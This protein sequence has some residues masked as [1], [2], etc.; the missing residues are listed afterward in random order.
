MKNRLLPLLLVT[1]AIPL[2]IFRAEIPTEEF[3]VRWFS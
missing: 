3:V 2:Q 1:L